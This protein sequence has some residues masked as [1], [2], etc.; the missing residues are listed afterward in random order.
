M[1]HKLIGK[2]KL[3]SQ[4]TWEG[5]KLTPEE[6]HAIVIGWG[7]GVNFTRTDWNEI[8]HIYGKEMKQEYHYYQFGRGVGLLTFVGV[9]G[10][11]ISGCIKLVMLGV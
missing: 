10:A 3:A 4:W 6:W 9:T 8:A 1:L 5:L 7:D 2:I 11:V